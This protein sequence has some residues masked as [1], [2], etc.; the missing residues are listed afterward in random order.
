MYLPDFGMFIER[1]AKGENGKARYEA[2][3]WFG[4]N[5]GSSSVFTQRRVRSVV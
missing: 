2:R 3:A 4:V 5:S 1:I